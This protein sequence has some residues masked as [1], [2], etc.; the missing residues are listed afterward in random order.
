MI[1]KVDNQNPEDYL[2]NG[3]CEDPEHEMCY[4]KKDWESLYS[5]FL[6]KQRVR[7]AIK[8]VD[9]GCM[10]CCDLM[11]LIKELGLEDEE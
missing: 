2:L 1:D 8:K 3:V 7:E 4:T 10:D 11:H 9:S 5:N 6:D